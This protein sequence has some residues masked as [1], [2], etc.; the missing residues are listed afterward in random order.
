MDLIILL[1]N[2]D[3]SSQSSL[4]KNFPK[5]DFI[6]TSGSAHRTSASMPQK[7]EGPYVYS[8]GNQ[9]KYLT[10][11]DLDINNNTDPISDVSAQEQKIKQLNNR[12][13]RL[14]KKDP[15][16]SLDDIYAGQ[17]NILSLIKRYRNDLS[18]AE[19]ILQKAKKN[20]IHLITSFDHRGP[21][22]RLVRISGETLVIFF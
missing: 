1:V 14:Q 15:A 13:K 8:N 19:T 17:D 11:V 3:R 7:P 21:S 10:V 12:L 5:A 20:Q 4:A 9:G 2:A 16:R 18:A 6:F 22:A